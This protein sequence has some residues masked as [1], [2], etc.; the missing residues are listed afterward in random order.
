[1]AE[2]VSIFRSP[3][4]SSTDPFPSAP[5]GWIRDGDNWYNTSDKCWYQR[6]GLGW[7]K[8]A[9]PFNNIALTGTLT[10]NDDTGVTGEFN[11]AI[12]TLKKIKV[13]NGIITELEVE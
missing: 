4:I 3:I 10:I 12:H 2:D 8:T 13:K 9:D 6:S 1:M 5:V 7:I 11:S